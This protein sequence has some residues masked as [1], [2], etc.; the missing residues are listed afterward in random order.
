MSEF[1]PR[2][3]QAFALFLTARIYAAK[4]DSMEKELHRLLDIEVG[5]HFSD[6]LYGI[7]WNL[8]DAE[9]YFER[10]FNRE[11]LDRDN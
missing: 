8:D 11:M 2:K 10:A 4:A 6:A 1:D 5:G 9:E 7:E 3:Q